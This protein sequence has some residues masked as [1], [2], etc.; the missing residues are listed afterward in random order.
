MP[1]SGGGGGGGGAAIRAGRAFVEIS[2]NDSQLKSVL[3]GARKLVFAF[4]AA[5]AVGIGLIGS[6]VSTVIA[7]FKDVVEHFDKINDAADRLSSSAEDVSALGYAAEQSGSNLEEM[8]ASARAMQKALAENPE[9]FQKFGLDPE[10]LKQ[11]GLADQFQAIADALDG[12][13]DPAEKT[14]AAMALMGRGGQQ[15]IPMLAELRKLRGEAGDVGA[16]VG[17]ADAKNAAKVADSFDRLG[18]ALRNT[19]RQAGAVLLPFADDI[20]AIANGLVLALKWARDL[21]PVMA[22]DASE[23]FR[24]AVAG[25][26]FGDALDFL[27]ET[28]GKT[29]QGI[30]DAIAAGDLSKAIEIGLAGAEVVWKQFVL[31]LTRG[32]NKFKDTFVDGWHDA[33]TEMK[34]A[35]ANAFKWMAE[36]ADRFEPQ[37]AAG[38]F[39]K[40][41]VAGAFE[42]SPVAAA[43]GKLAGGMTEEQIRAK[44]EEEKAARRAARALDEAAAGAEANAAAANLEAQ[45]REAAITRWSKLSG[46]IAVAALLGINRQNQGAALSGLLGMSR[47]QFGGALAAQT[48]GV[49]TLQQK[50]LD[51]QIDTNRKLDRIEKKIGGLPV[52]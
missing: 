34:V 47:G 16:I 45:T 11:L 43:G 13:T 8:T 49:G 12:V 38:K 32:W 6:A 42:T 46:E 7:S 35:I 17:S 23:F 27:G 14:A 26:A 5:A 29:W 1:M 51:Q 20:E 19:F 10:K 4:A 15:M 28:F 41:L 36:Q 37:S 24:G 3:A 44:A 48:L 25:T 22:K 52:D 2:A 9:A 40:G 30:K 39:F 33:V 31:N 18:T 21:G 50:Q